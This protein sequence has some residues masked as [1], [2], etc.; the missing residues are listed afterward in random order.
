MKK[1]SESSNII[2]VIAK[3]DSLTMEERVAFKR[4]IKEEMDFH[5][6]RIFPYIDIPSEDPDL[7]TAP[8]QAPAISDAERMERQ[9]SLSIREMI[10]FAV[11]GSERNIV[12]DGKAVRGRRTRWGLINGKWAIHESRALP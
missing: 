9:I 3:A 8:G 1:L 5:G 7:I 10:P 4:R 12:I 2:P 11:V 6:I